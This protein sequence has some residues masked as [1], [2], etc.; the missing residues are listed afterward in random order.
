MLVTPSPPSR[1]TRRA[2]WSSLPSTVPSPCRCVGGWE[3]EGGGRGCKKSPGLRFRPRASLDAWTKESRAVRRDH[4]PSPEP[5]GGV[6]AHVPPHFFFGPLILARRPVS[7]RPL[8]GSWMRLSAG[9]GRAFRSTL[10]NGAG[11]RASWRSTTRAAETSRPLGGA[12]S[13]P[14]CARYPGLCRDRA[15]TLAHPG[16]DEVEGAQV[17]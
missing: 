17:R 11:T 4:R 15:L 2:T 16:V 5:R 9:G 1:R 8:R 7:S 14:R 10:R 6:L 3:G 12:C 13:Q